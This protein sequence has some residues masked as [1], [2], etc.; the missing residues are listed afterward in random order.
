MVSAPSAGSTPVEPLCHSFGGKIHGTS[1]C[2]TLV[3]AS[4]SLEASERRVGPGGADVSRASCKKSTPSA[5]LVVGV[6]RMHVDC[7]Y[8]T[9]GGYRVEVRVRVVSDP[10]HP[11]LVGRSFLLG[12]GGFTDFVNVFARTGP[13]AGADEIDFTV[14]FGVLD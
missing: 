5:E 12:N 2:K 11:S 8:T 4:G 3:R 10:S 9:D 1:S 13:D 7:E 6:I 14:D